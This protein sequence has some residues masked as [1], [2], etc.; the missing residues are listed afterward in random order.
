MGVSLSEFLKQGSKRVKVKDEIG[1]T[2]EFKGLE[3]VALGST[4]PDLVETLCR[5]YYENVDSEVWNQARTYGVD[6]AASASNLRLE[7]RER[8][9]LDWLR[10]WL[11]ANDHS[12]R[13]MTKFL[14]LT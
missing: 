13:Q 10:E 3:G 4:E 6:I 2:L 7:D 11:L 1:Y 9:A 14:G 5:N 8:E 12:H